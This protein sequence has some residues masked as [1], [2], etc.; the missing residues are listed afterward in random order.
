VYVTGRSTGVDGG[1]DYA[2]VAYDA[3]SSAELWVRRYKGPGA[4]SDQAV[5]IAASPDGSRVYVTG[6]SSLDY[7]TIAYEGSTGAKLWLRRYSAGFD[8]EAAAIAVSPDGALVWVTG[9]SYAFATGDWDY[10]SVAYAGDSGAE[11]WLSRYDGPSHGPDVATSLAV[12][13]EPVRVYVTGYSSGSSFK[14]DYATVAYAGRTG[15]ELWA[16]RYDGPSH[17][18]DTAYS[19]AVGPDAARVYVTGNSPGLVAAGG[20]ATV[21][22]D[23]ATGAELWVRRYN[24]AGNG[25]DVASSIAVGPDGAGVYVTGHSRGSGS[26]DDYAT[27]AYDPTTGAKLWV[28]RYNGTGNG[29]D[30]ASALSVSQDG[31][32][33]YVTGFST[34]SISGEDYA[35][36]TY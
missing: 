8:D 33:V 21:A 25:D 24:G 4:G 15:T 7:A 1:L 2:T 18:S 17:D 22:Y 31:A 35:T 19:V 34:G 13:Q 23:A 28:H 10:A 30:H 29:D 9:R 32:D 20:Y 36:L 14:T 3:G 26:G 16:N 27:L 5:A 11:I 12:T 6:T